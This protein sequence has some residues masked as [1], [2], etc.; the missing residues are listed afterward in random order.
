LFDTTQ[1]YWRVVERVTDAVMALIDHP[2]SS[3]QE[4]IK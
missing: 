2:D 1:T 4:T 3:N